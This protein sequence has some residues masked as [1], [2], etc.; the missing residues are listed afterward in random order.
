MDGSQVFSSS[1][2]WESPYRSGGASGAGS[3]GGLPA[4]RHRS[5]TTSSGITRF[6]A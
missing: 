6:K 4:S 2:Y 5:S 1:A 3:L